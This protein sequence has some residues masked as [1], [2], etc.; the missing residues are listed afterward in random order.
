MTFSTLLPLG[1]LVLVP[2]LIILYFLRPRGKETKISSNLLWKQLFDRAANRTK[3]SRFVRDILLLLQLFAVLLLILSLMSPRVKTGR[4]REENV[5]ILMDTSAG[6]M[7]LDGK[8]TRLEKAVSEAVEMVES[9]GD[10]S[11]TVITSG[12]ST[13]I[14]IANSGDKVKVAGVLKDITATDEAGN[15]KDAFDIVKTMQESA[16][17]EPLHVIIFTDG[18]GALGAVD[19]SEKLDAEIRVYGGGSKN[20]AVSS[21]SFA[22][23]S[24]SSTERPL[25]DFAAGISNYSDSS[26]EFEVTLFDENG[27]VL[28][29]SNLKCDAGLSATA[30]FKGVTWE[31]NSARVELSGISFDGGGSDSLD[32]DNT[33]FVVKDKKN[34]IRGMLIGQGNIYIEKAFLAIAKH[35]IVIAAD[36]SS[37]KKRDPNIIIY[38]AGTTAKYDTSSQSGGQG[39]SGENGGQSG[40]GKGSGDRSLSGVLRF[41]IPE[42]KAEVEKELE[43]AVLN[44]RDTALTGVMADFTLGVNK[45]AVLKVPEWAESFIEHNGDPVGYYGEKN[46]VRYIVL[47]FDIRESDFPLSAEFPIFMSNA[48]SYL[49]DSGILIKNYYTA[50][51]TLLANPSPIY[52]SILLREKLTEAGVFTISVGEGAEKFVVRFP[53]SESD[54]RAVSEGTVSTGDYTG[55]VLRKK[56]S[57]MLIILAIVIVL[58]EFFIYAKSMRYRG[59]FYIVTRVLTILLLGAALLKPYIPIGAIDQTTIFLVDASVSNSANVSEISSYISK[60]VKSAGKTD[61]FGVIVFGKDTSIDQFVTDEKSY[62]GVMAVANDSAT[63][64]EKAVGR[65][66]TMI[67]SDSAGRIVIITDGRET[68]GNVMNTAAAV[69]GGDIEILSII[70][71]DEEKPDAYIENATLPESVSYGEIFSINVTVISNIEAPAVIYLEDGDGKVYQDEISLRKGSNRYT[72]KNK[73]DKDKSGSFKLSIKAEG[74]ENPD[75]D[76]FNVFTAL[77]D[78]PAVL[79]V[80]GSGRSDS[81]FEKVLQQAGVNYDSVSASNAPDEL[82]EMLAYESIIFDNVFLSDVPSGFVDN[83]EEYVKDYGHG[84]I[85]CGGE[86]SFMLGGYRDTA[87]EK[88]LPVDMSMRGMVEMPSTAMIMVID[89]SGSMLDQSSG[90]NGATNLDVALNAAILAVENLSPNDYVGVITFDDQY[91]WTVPVQKASDK[92]SIKKAIKEINQ[93]GGTTIKPAV[94][95]AA[96]GIKDVNAANKHIILLTDG[97]GETQDFDDAIKLINDNKVTLSTVAVGDYSD[98]ML[99]SRLAAACGGRYYFSRGAND[100]PKIFTQEIYLSMSNYLQNGDFSLSVS[101]SHPVTKGLFAGGW[102]NLLGYI[103]SSPKEMSTGLIVSNLDDPILTVWQYGL[104]R[105][106]AWNTDVS[107]RWSANLSGEN[108]YAAM[109]KRL[110]DYTI[111]DNMS[112]SDKVETKTEN[113]KTVVTYKTNEFGN[114]T[115]IYADYKNPEGKE[116]KL[117]FRMVEP[118]LY[119]AVL[120]EDE[121][122]VYDLNVVREDDGKVIN[123]VN[124]AAVLQYPKEYRFDISSKNFREYIEKYGREINMK[125]NIWKEMNKHYTGRFFITWI[126]VLLAL[127]LF[128]ADITLRKLGFMYFKRKKKAAVKV[129]K[130]EEGTEAGAY[131]IEAGTSSGKKSSKSG[132]SGAKGKSGREAQAGNGGLDMSELL[133]KKNERNIR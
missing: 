103:A 17:E 45:A 86:N 67:P 33:S 63:D 40:S 109:W 6:M 104:G 2:Y 110:V 99:L 34:D 88:V 85:C 15:L 90:G 7:H 51:D 69:T 12:G 84:F 73:V 52:D 120:D 91:E 111:N 112:I 92:E 101:G 79:V 107:G 26:A 83:L 14:R 127:F 87:V 59:V 108:D 121:A 39:G 35:D 29:I 1:L 16:G 116:G 56:I 129:N 60:Q 50:G 89:R 10:T 125:E 21:L 65:A 28:G 66:M 131:G 46:G 19:Y 126:L 18:S 55:G 78:A 44:F 41:G 9:S 105:T 68:E 62:G 3:R 113:G 97:M 117:E 47:G 23:S 27:A 74:D 100:I 20:A 128:T 58:A 22:A 106:A 94:L 13:D 123:S 80:F 42:D 5:L 4:S 122:G 81:A 61:N 8:A 102:P 36:D 25:Y 31:G 95:A 96:N 38:D 75:N 114:G 93:G 70:F 48:I 53:A 82:K 132:K 11:F 118:G 43:G 130:L 119:Q 77:G 115:A 30:V 49:S 133:K 54:G 37:A 64:I 24:Q 32:R 124:T 98:V 72:F 71:E 76:S 57:S